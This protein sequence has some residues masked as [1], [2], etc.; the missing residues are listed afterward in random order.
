M[1]IWPKKYKTNITKK[2]NIKHQWKKLSSLKKCWKYSFENEKRKIMS[3]A[4]E[5]PGKDPISKDKEASWK[6]QALTHCQNTLINLKMN[7]FVLIF[8]F[9][10]WI[11]KCSFETVEKYKGKLCESVVGV[12][13]ER[14][15]FNGNKQRHGMKWIIK[16]NWI[17][18]FSFHI[19]EVNSMWSDA[20]RNKC[21]SPC[22]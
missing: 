16:L 13:I 2:I 14:K 22:V 3:S 10:K 17:I 6:I 11:W 18:L 15:K 20:P 21:L 7:F 12:Q 8:T 9:M 1:F 19:F 5:N 4:P